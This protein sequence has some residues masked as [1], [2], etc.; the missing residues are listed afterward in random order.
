MVLFCITF[1][2]NTFGTK[3]QTNEIDNKLSISESNVLMKLSL[4]LIALVFA[5]WLITKGANLILEEFNLG[6]LFIGYTVLAIGTSLP[7]IA[8][9]F[10]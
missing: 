7:E 8:A 5:A 1:F 9:Q 2:C 3:R 4:S 6:E 10:H